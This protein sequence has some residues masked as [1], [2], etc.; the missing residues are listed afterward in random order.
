[1]NELDRNKKIEINEAFEINPNKR[2]D[3]TKYRNSNGIEALDPNKRVSE[4]NSQ[5][6]VSFVVEKQ[7]EIKNLN[8]KLKAHLEENKILEQDNINGA[9]LYGPHN[10]KEYWNPNNLRIGFCNLETYSLD[11]NNK[12]DIIPLDANTLD[13][14]TDKAENKNRAN[15]TITNT[16]LLNYCIRYALEN[17]KELT[18]KDISKIKKEISVGGENY[19]YNYAQMDKSEYFNFRYSVPTDSPR[20]HEKYILEKYQNDPFYEK[21]YKDFLLITDPKIL[22][23]GGEFGVDRLTAMFPELKGELQHC[24]KPVINNGRMIVSIKHPGWISD[25]EIANTVNK[26]TKNIDKIDDTKKESLFSEMNR[27]SEMSFTEADSGHVNPNLEECDGFQCNCQTCV[28]VFE[29]RLRGYDIEARPMTEDSNAMQLSEKTN[30]AWLTEDGKHP[31]YIMNFEANSVDAIY[32]FIDKTVK[33]GERYTLEGVWKGFFGCGH[34]IS[35]FR[36]TTGN[37]VF[38]DPQINQIYSK[39]VMK[40][41][42][43]PFMQKGNTEETA[44]KLL[45]IDNLALNT[46]F[47]EPIVRRSEN[48]A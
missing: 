17:K 24:G 37:L 12:D 16:Y 18:V 9:F 40:E 30:L 38:Y 27:G 43:L 42:F 39:R 5:K 8:S 11:K 4:L 23:V 29:A 25:E 10:S 46:E 1:M 21:H 48:H 36:E 15:P 22:I 41:E 28:V 7:L 6:E 19:D 2:I 34:I 45:R 47:I 13:G 35:V 31:D 3:T 26:I 20:L 14:W 44:I 32:D 33:S